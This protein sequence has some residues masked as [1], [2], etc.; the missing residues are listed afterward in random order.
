LAFIGPI[1][2]A[3]SLSLQQIVEKQRSLPYVVW[4]PIGF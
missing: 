2:L 4:Q 1:L 3:D